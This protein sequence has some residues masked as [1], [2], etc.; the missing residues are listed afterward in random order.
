MESLVNANFDSKKSNFLVTSLC[1]MFLSF[2]YD[3]S[4]T[5]K[6]VSFMLSDK[7][8]Q[9]FNKLKSILVEGSMLTQP[10]FG[11]E[12]VGYND[13]SLNDLRCVLMQEGKV[14]AYASLQLQTHGK[15]YPTRDLE[16]A[17]VIFML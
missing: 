1:E 16:L 11:K 12:F 15:N 8:Q 17:V 7:C 6:N 9:S 14:I 10:E 5:K 4:A 2:T 3:E 13:A